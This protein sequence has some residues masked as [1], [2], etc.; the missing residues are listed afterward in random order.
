MTRAHDIYRAH[1]TDEEIAD[2]LGQRLTAAVGT[3]NEDGSIHLAYV[4]FLFDGTRFFFETAS[5][6]NKARN[7]AARDQASIMIQGTA[8]TGRNL[9][10][11]A[12]GTPRVL[13]GDEAREVNH[14]IR[15]KYVEADAVGPLDASWDRFDDVAVRI[16]PVRWRSWTGSVLHE[17]TENELGRPYEGIWLPDE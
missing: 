16:T 2:V 1:P 5:V 9:M 14:R 13:I 10:V 7:A 11:A 8:A 6:T 12:E 4:I 3:L 15:T 17:V